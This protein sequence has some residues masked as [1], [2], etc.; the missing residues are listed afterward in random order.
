M[1][2]P[3]ARL[4]PTAALLAL[5]AGCGGSPAA[6]VIGPPHTSGQQSGA[7]TSVQAG[8]APHVLVSA[9][10]WA[11]P[12][13]ISRA[14]AFVLSGGNVFIGGGMRPDQSSSARAYTVNLGTGQPSRL[15]NLPVDV[16]DAAA[17]LYQGEVAVYG[18]GN[19]TEQATVQVLKAGQ[20]TQGEQLP[21]S[22]SDLSVISSGGT[23]YVF[24]GY[25]GSRATRSVLSQ[26]GASA[27]APAGHLKVGVR[28]AAAAAYQGTVYLFGGEVNNTELN[29]VQAYDI[30]TG[31]TRVVAHLPV[32]LGHAM[33]V[34]V[35][36][37]ILVIGGKTD[38]NT[39]I[40]GIRW[41]DPATRKFS[42]AGRLPQPLSDGFA[43]V[44][45]GAT[46]QPVVYVLG[47]EHSG[48]KVTNEVL[49]IT[50][51]P[52]HGKRG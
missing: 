33:A 44:Y 34:T 6:K 20:W 1:N 16:H 15:P 46:G 45:S 7:T 32:G 5:V 8:R 18:G 31:R 35:G 47:G 52:G 9:A 12:A 2:K 40:D 26:A 14:A 25:D 27:L 23:T 24:G 48:G 51:K 39:Q 38:T 41:F 42:R 49:V 4:V 43:A 30:Q 19:S 37:R 21:T 22:R 10:G 13:P 17:G 11:L 3:L 29:T 36:S 50:E 28:Y